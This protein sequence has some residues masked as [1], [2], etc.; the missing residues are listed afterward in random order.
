MVVRWT[1]HVEALAIQRKFCN[2]VLTESARTPP[3]LED[4]DINTG[5]E[6][7][8]ALHGRRAYV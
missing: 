3:K 7:L 1:A 6:Q 4:G 5:F 8:V 2:E